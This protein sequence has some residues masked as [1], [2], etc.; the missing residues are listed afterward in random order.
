LIS[1]ASPFEFFAEEIKSERRQAKLRRLKLTL[2]RLRE[3]FSDG[4]D[5]IP[6]VYY[7]GTEYRISIAKKLSTLEDECDDDKQS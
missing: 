2:S 7:I 3:L 4:F 1:D 5:T 6:V